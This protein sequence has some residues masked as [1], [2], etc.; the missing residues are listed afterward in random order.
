[1]VFHYLPGQLSRRKF[2]GQLVLLRTSTV[3]KGGMLDVG[4]ADLS[5]LF[6]VGRGGSAWTGLAKSRLPP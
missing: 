5:M 2:P 1:M 4:K 6:K 3:G